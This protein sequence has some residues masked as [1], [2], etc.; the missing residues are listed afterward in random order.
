MQNTVTQGDQVFINVELLSDTIDTIR[1]NLQKQYSDNEQ[2][3]L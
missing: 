1:K 3:L 2:F